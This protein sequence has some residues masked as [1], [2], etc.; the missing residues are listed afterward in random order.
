MEIDEITERLR[1]TAGA[2]SGGES[3]LDYALVYQRWFPE[4]DFN[5]D[6]FKKLPKDV[7][8][9]F[10]K[11]VIGTIFYEYY[12]KTYDTKS[13]LSITAHA[14]KRVLRAIT[15]SYR[16]D[17]IDIEDALKARGLSDMEIADARTFFI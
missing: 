15:Q 14:Y 1:K 9:L 10:A 11:D 16:I 6:N 5:L 2:L 7:I 8:T 12:H 17:M 3:L 4:K 13:E